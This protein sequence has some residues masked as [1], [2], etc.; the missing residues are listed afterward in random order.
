MA[1]R[2]TRVLL[3]VLVAGLVAPA[4]AHEL[5]FHPGAG[6]AAGWA[7]LTFG[8]SPDLDAA[9]RATEI[10]HAQV[11]ADGQRLAV[12][13]RPDGLEVRLPDHPPA[14]LSA[15]ADRGVVNSR[16]DAFVI[17]LAAYAQAQAVEPGQAERLG[18]GDQQVRLLL[19]TRSE[20][21]PV[22]QAS[23]RGQAVA[24][25]P[26]K[27]FHQGAAAIDM[28]TDGQGRIPC[29]DLG[30]GPCWLLLEVR[31]QKPG[32]RNSQDYSHIR[33]KAT[34]AIAAQ[35]ALRPAAADCLARVRDLHGA[36][37][38]WAVA[39]YRIGARA[40]KELG[41]PRHSQNLDVVHHCPAEV[42]YSCIADGV[43]AATGAS[44]G[45]LNLGI[46][47]APREHLRTLIRDKAS[48]RTLIFTLT[49]ELTRSIA[50]LP[51]DRL[52]AEGQR[53][54]QLPDDCIFQISTSH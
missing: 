29:P 34:L 22:V 37:G 40:L 7:R 27:L 30:K 38:P 45:K 41:L 9:K 17:Q 25:A 12:Q 13:R 48:G 10:E 14:V 16:G 28:Q 15:F 8:D 43:Q 5:W 18:L 19:I 51:Q 21:P 31:D 33:Y 42:Q 52:E 3:G 47:T 39:G 23:W 26:I 4:S 36:A 35:A 50:N 20:G 46:K 53:V 2:L 54:A 11:W 6:G 1:M 24:N 49:P 32:R 44:P